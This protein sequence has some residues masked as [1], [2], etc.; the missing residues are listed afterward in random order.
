MRPPRH[1]TRM[2]QSKKLANGT[3]MEVATKVVKY[4]RGVMRRQPE[5]IN[6]VPFLSQKGGP[7]AMR[8]QY[9]VAEYHP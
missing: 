3:Y 2:Y 4:A 1:N 5:N 6:T 7:I 9:S 8:W